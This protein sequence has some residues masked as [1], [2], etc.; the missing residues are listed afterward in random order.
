MI[1]SDM[2]SANIYSSADT[3]VNLD[4]PLKKQP[5]YYKVKV[6]LPLFNLNTGNYVIK[7]LM[8][9]INMELFDTVELNFTIENNNYINKG[10]RPGLL[11][12]LNKWEYI[13][14]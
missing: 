4:L 5:G 10:T 9:I 8:G 11:F 7:L 6:P 14:D 2:L 13:N 12:A 3:D 1:I